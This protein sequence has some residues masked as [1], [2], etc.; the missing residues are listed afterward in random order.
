[1]PTSTGAARAIGQ[2]L[3]A[4]DGKLTGTALRVPVPVGSLTDLTARV[5]RPTSAAE[6]NGFFA[7]AAAGGPLAG[8]LRYADAPLVSSDIV[9]D[10]ASCVFD[11][12]LTQVTGGGRQVKVFGWYDNESGFAH[13]VLD[14]ARLVGAPA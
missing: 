7:E 10:P 12:Q 8:V 6:V 2:V 11:S 9:G 5:G 1:M 4:L 3:P 13:R 14:V